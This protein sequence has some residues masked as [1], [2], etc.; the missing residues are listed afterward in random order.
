[1][2]TE[3]PA[4]AVSQR[5]WSAV[6]RKAKEEWLALFADGAK[7]EDPVGTSL[8]DPDGKGHVG[9]EAISRFW[10]ANIAPNTVEINFTKSFAAGQEVAH[11]G[12]IAT[13]FGEGMMFPKGTKITVEGVFVYKVNEAG[14][15]ISLRGFWEFDQAMASLTPPS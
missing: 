12:T 2:A 4:R 9:R 11:V 7:I 15:L 8:L 3:H 14:K 13:T 5:S 6:H 10:D 1:M